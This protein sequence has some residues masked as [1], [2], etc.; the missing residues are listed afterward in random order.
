MFEQCLQ[1]SPKVGNVA[2]ILSN[3]GIYNILAEKAP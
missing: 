3:S 1:K 2:Q